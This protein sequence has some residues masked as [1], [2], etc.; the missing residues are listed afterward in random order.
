MIFYWFKKIVSIFLSPIVIFLVLLLLAYIA[1]RFDKL[2]LSR[3]VRTTAYVFL[4]LTTMPFSSKWLIA[5]LESISPPQNLTS[6]EV[7][8][9]S[10][11]GCTSYQQP[12][13][14]IV[15]RLADCSI[16][17]VTQGII[18]AHKFPDATLYF[19]GLDSVTDKTNAELGAELAQIMGIDEKRIVVING[20][21]DTRS[22]A[23]YIKARLGQGTQL[24]VVTDASH[25]PRS[26]A[27]FKEQQLK[28]IGYPA[29]YLANKIYWGSLFNYVPDYRSLKRSQRA[30]YEYVALAW[31]HIR[32]Y[33]VQNA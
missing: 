11:L 2:R 5:P 9:I 19:S 30:L 21:R 18:L 29:D 12:Q 3:A 20:T 8:H 26:L 23:Q 24:L 27:L 1:R 15:S 14:P 4:L 25:L 7:A 28:P 32:L 13:W 10:V 31:T 17:R 16:K 33:F 22:E 6:S